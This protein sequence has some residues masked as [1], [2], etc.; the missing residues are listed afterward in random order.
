MEITDVTAVTVDVPLADLDDHLGIGPYVTNHGRLDSMERVLVRVDTDEGISGWG[1]MRV[2]LSPE[3]TESII[4]DGVGPMIRG[5]SPFEIERLRRQVFVEYTNVDMFF[6]AVETAC[7]DIVGKAL[8]R[9]VYELLGGWTA[10]TQGTQ[11]HRQNI[12]GDD[13][14]PS[15]VPV[16]FCLGILSPEES[17]AKA[18]E[19]LDAGFSVLKT[20]AGRDWREDVERIE[21]MHDETDG[22]LEFRL[23][24]NQGWTLEQAVRVGAMLEDSGIYLQYME[25]PIRVDSHRSLARLRQRLRQPIAPNEDTYISHNIQSLIEA[26]AMDVGVIDLTPAGGIS[27]IRQQAAVLEDAG[28]PFTHH[29]AFDLGIRTAAI[30]H[31]VTGIPGFSLPPDSTYYGWD[32]EVIEHPFEVSDG[33]LPA[34]EGPG[35]GISVDMDAVAEYR[36]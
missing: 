25:Q 2:F 5:Q 6:A 7:W 32:G 16:A 35:L 23:D 24:P 10:P 18:R 33:C 17:R 13:A 29:C 28:V 15:P 34:P 22:Q 14:S 12:E 11:Q 26:G 20:K 3:A 8:D 31:G 36:C 9:P 27:G 30:L 21:A 4:E 1:E 19:A